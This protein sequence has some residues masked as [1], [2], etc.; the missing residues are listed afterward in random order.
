[1]WLNLSAVC[2]GVLCGDANCVILI[3]LLLLLLLFSGCV[4]VDGSAVGAYMCVGWGQLHVVHVPAFAFDMDIPI[5]LFL[6][7]GW[8]SAHC[9]WYGCTSIFTSCPK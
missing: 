5:V 1:L 6:L 4:G 7:G 2:R 3:L 8:L 9:A